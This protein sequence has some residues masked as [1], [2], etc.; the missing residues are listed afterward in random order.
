MKSLRFGT[1]AGVGVGV[2]SSVTE[3]PCTRARGSFDT[4]STL[5]SVAYRTFAGIIATENRHLLSACS[6]QY[7]LLHV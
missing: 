2:L 4:V 7:A 5:F 6:V 1:Y 3:Q